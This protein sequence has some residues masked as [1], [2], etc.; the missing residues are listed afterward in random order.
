MTIAAND[1]FAR[2]RTVGEIAASL[3]G[4]T[5]VFRRFGLDFCCKGDVALD[6]SARLHGVDVGEVEQALSELPADGK[7]EAPSATVELIDHILARY[8]EVHRRELRELVQLAR[9]VEKVHAGNPAVPRGLADLL[10]R[11]AQGLEQHMAKE[12]LILFPAM[13]K[14]MPGLEAPIARMRHEHHDHGRTLE[15]LEALTKGFTVPSGACR[16]W[17]TLYAGASKFADDL[18]QHI[19]LE[20]NVLFPRFAGRTVL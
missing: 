10:D 18:R 6:E 9:T 16:T 11:T 1:L 7:A 14:A 3:P 19:H 17:Q 2:N 12:E 13:A 15:E 4:A 8:H 5:A 20:N